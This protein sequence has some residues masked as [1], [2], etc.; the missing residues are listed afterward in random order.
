MDDIDGLNGMVA[1]LLTDIIKQV[2]DKI[3][4]LEM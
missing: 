4:W 2:F 3:R 1:C